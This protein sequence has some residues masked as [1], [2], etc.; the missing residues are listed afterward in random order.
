MFEHAQAKPAWPLPELTGVPAGSW[1]SQ[2]PAQ[3][4]DNFI[5]TTAQNHVDPPVCI[6]FSQGKCKYGFSCKFKHTGKPP[7]AKAPQPDENGAPVC[8]FFLRGVCQKGSGCRFRHEISEAPE[9]S[10]VSE[11]AV[12]PAPPAPFHRPQETPTTQVTPETTFNHA[13]ELSK[14]LSGATVIFGDGVAVQSI[15]LRSDFSA[16]QLSHVHLDVNADRIAEFVASL[17]FANV[18]T[19]CIQLKPIPDG[20]EQVAEIRVEDP[21]FADNFLRQA[22][23]KLR[24]DGRTLAATR[25]QHADGD[26]GAKRL[27][28]STVSCA[29]FKP[30]KV[31][32]IHFDKKDAA[33][34]AVK[35][36]GKR[37]VRGRKLQVTYQE[38][39]RHAYRGPGQ[40]I[41]SVQVG[42]LHVDTT[43][44]DLFHALSGKKTN[45]VKWGPASYDTPTHMVE[46]I[47]RRELEAFGPLSDWEVIND[48]TGIKGKAT[49]RYVNAEDARKAAYQLNGR[50]L[51][52]LGNSKVHVSA[53]V[54]IKL[55]VQASILRAVQADVDELK[56]QLWEAH[57]VHIK[58]YDA[59][60]H[61]LHMTLRIYGDDRQAVAKAKGSVEK[62]LAGTVA[63][64]GEDPIQDVY[65]FQPAGGEFVQGVMEEHSALVYRDMKK[66]L[67]RIYGPPKAVQNAE[68]A[69]RKRKSELSSMAHTIPLTPQSLRSALHGGFKHLV[70]TF[71]KDAVKIDI[72]GTPKT[73]TFHG[74]TEEF[75]KVSAILSGT[76]DDEAEL[77]RRIAALSPTDED[78]LCAV[79][80][81]TPE[82]PIRRDCGHTYCRECLSG[83]CSSAGE[84]T[85]IPIRCL[86]GGSESCN[87]VMTLREL[88]DA[89][90]AA[91]FETLLQKAFSSYIRAR[92][93]VFQFC[94]TPDCD[95]VYRCSTDGR[96]VLCDECLVD[97]CT[98]CHVA[99][100]DGLS[101]AE[102]KDLAGDGEAAFRKWREEND[103]RA[104]PKCNTNIEKTYGCNHMTCRGCG[105]HIC[106][107]CMAVFQSSGDTYAHMGKA[108]ESI[109]F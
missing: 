95:R 75:E 76:G 37:T 27:Q 107:F 48:D 40:I 43:S 96:T 52:E 106:W 46:R 50:K 56:A 61:S 68:A 12:A 97:V 92:L 30:S 70:E 35:S 53:I 103:V 24:M 18:R 15:S 62:I 16:V 86:G 28:L 8:T 69:L 34:A 58:S 99:A 51:P 39:P 29:W 57:H 64:D 60:T 19:D 7:T 44:P 67:L 4:T 26:S 36:L 82:D 63:T 41:H 23:H 93:D 11:V 66:T 10:A 59:P 22:G 90:P 79:C 80:W 98:T 72:T 104:C 5:P 20:S 65:F 45:G 81:T 3:R 13:G 78:D 109:G 31:A 9:K 105:I 1:I 33:L 55:S 87:E 91:A 94:P 6:F 108:H 42:N 54:S 74:S 102:A 101:C 21:S 73:V 85:G 71:G 25:I 77:Q 14:A 89:L 47:M 84:G 38:P 32:W 83:Q 100:H 2:P 49:A 17:G 88:S